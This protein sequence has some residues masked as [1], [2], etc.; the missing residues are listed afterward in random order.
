MRLTTTAACDTRP[1]TD[2]TSTD[3]QIPPTSSPPTAVRL[4]TVQGA[5]SSQASS[6]GERGRSAAEMVGEFR[7]A[8][9]VGIGGRR[10]C[11]VGGAM[12]ALLSGTVEESRTEPGV[13]GSCVMSHS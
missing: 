10:R 11:V 12:P 13:R 5:E 1:V 4:R 8:P 3:L 6:L 9:D 2:A 7:E